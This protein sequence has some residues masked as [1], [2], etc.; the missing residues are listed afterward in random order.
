[1]EDDSDTIGGKSGA[2]SSSGPGGTS[3]KDFYYQESFKGSI[4]NSFGKSRELHQQ[5][6]QQDP[7]RP[8]TGSG[9]FEMKSSSNAHSSE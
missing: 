5:I 2:K 1:M 7:E 6:Y 4:N 3:M 9:E 8:Y